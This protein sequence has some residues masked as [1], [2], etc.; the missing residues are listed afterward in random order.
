MHIFIVALCFC[1]HCAYFATGAVH[2]WS[3]SQACPW[4]R[5]L[6]W[7]MRSFVKIFGC[8]VWMM[9]SIICL[10][11]SSISSWYFVLFYYARSTKENEKNMIGLQSRLSIEI[12][13]M[14]NTSGLSL[15][16]AYTIWI[17]DSVLFRYKAD[18]IISSIGTCNCSSK[19]YIWQN[20]SLGI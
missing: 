17:Q 6:Q 5:M 3:D 15:Q 13:D 4:I 18:N 11:M 2:G 16:W 1:C 14:F 12:S 10:I 20:S 8:L 7:I 19:W 9:V